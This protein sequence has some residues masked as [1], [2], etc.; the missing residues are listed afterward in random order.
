MNPKKFSTKLDAEL[1]ADECC[2]N[3][4]M[5]A[6]RGNS[7]SGWT[8]DA[9]V[10]TNSSLIFYDLGNDGFFHEHHRKPVECEC[11]VSRNY[12]PSDWSQRNGT[13]WI[14]SGCGK[15]IKSMKRR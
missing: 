8:I 3:G 7:K 9:I 10:R 13:E 1:A 11:A 2:D 5:A 6:V 4:W 14:C 15:V 12:N